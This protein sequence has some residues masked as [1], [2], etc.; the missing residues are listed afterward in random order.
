MREF[1]YFIL[2]FIISILV[3][4]GIAYLIW[5]IKGRKS[6]LEK[7]ADRVFAFLVWPGWL[8]LV[9]ILCLVLAIFFGILLDYLF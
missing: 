9:F 1:Y 4:L 7:E 3:V 6:S 8:W 2:E 5:R